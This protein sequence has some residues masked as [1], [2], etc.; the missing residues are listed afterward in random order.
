MSETSFRH[1]IVPKWH[2]NHSW[3]IEQTYAITFMFAACIISKY[4]T[5]SPW[6]LQ[7]YAF[8]H[9]SADPIICLINNINNPIPKMPVF[10]FFR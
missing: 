9:N 10:F 7:N 3:L 4:C 1:V 5:Q 2:N 8:L 6:L